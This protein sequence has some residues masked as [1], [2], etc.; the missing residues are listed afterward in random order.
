MSNL[1]HFFYELPRNPV[2]PPN[3]VMLSG[4]PIDD[5]DTELHPSE[6]E[7]TYRLD[8]RSQQLIGQ[9]TITVHFTDL[10]EDVPETPIDKPPVEEPVPTPPPVP[11]V[12]QLLFDFE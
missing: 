5:P 3:R 4:F 2:W 8:E 9:E 1:Q 12:G 10:V 11:E 6:F 7:T